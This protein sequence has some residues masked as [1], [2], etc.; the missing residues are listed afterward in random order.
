MQALASILQPLA[1]EHNVHRR[2]IR[3]R[4]AIAGGPGGA[5]VLGRF[6]AAEKAGAM[7]GGERRRLVEEEQLGPTAA[8]HHIPP[9]ALVLADADDPGFRRPAARQQRP[10]PRSV[11]D[12]AIAHEHAAL[13]NGDNLA[14]GRY[15]ILQRHAGSS[16]YLV[17][18]LP[19]GQ[20]RE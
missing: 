10:R 2:R 6:A 13:G 12:A 4:A 9:H 5:K 11:N 14:E 19:G 8:T 18:G 15:A 16:A 20:R 7:S 17:S 3:S 1:M